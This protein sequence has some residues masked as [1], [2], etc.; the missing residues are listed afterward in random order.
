MQTIEK[1][2]NLLFALV[3]LHPDLFPLGG[4]TKTPSRPQ[5]GRRLQFDLVLLLLLRLVVLRL[6]HLLLFLFQLLHT[7]AQTLKS[8]DS[9]N[10]KN[11]NVLKMQK[12]RDSLKWNLR[13]LDDVETDVEKDVD[14]EVLTLSPSLTFSD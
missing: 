7:L 12:L 10:G 6:N 3:E 11:G 14:T 13:Y 4:R 5:G 8:P 1:R 9:A 2:P